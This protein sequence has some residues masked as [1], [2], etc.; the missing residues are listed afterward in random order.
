MT[1]LQPWPGGLELHRA[2]HVGRKVWMLY[3]TFGACTMYNV[4]DVAI[5]LSVHFSVT[6]TIQWNSDTFGTSKKRP[7]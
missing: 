2:L 5:L 3:L 7:D 4:D 6:L 1:V